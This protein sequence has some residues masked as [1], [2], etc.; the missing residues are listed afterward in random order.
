M[1]KVRLDIDKTIDSKSVLTVVIMTG[2]SES[3][4]RALMRPERKGK[5]LKD[6]DKDNKPKPKA[7]A[8]M[9]KFQSTQSQKRL[10]PIQRR[11]A[12]GKIVRVR[13]RI[14]AK[15]RVEERREIQIPRLI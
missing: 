12:L 1:L 3:S 9:T 13:G 11:K 14:K 6:K 15:V 7:A 2:S 5:R 4:R 10:S 8:A